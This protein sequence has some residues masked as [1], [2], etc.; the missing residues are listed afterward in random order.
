MTAVY[1]A[2]AFIAAE[3]GDR[4]M[5]VRHKAALLARQPPVT[6]AAVI[7]QV[8]RGQPRQARLAAFAASV[9]PVSLTEPVARAA[10][11]LLARAGTADVIDAAVL[12]AAADGDVVYTSD[13]DDLARL[14]SAANRRVEIVPV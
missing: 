9:Q 11:V 6:S 2:G 1:D 3:R 4:A 7:G 8:W 14:A 10:G 13:H 5:W 12:L